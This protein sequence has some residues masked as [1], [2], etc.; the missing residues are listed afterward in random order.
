MQ[1]RLPVTKRKG[2]FASYTERPKSQMSLEGIF[3]AVCL[4]HEL[5]RERLL[6]DLDYSHRIIFLGNSV[7]AA[8]RCFIGWNC[9]AA[10]CGRGYFHAR[11]GRST[12]T[13]RRR[14]ELNRLGLDWQA[15]GRR[16]T[17]THT[18]D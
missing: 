14:D 1:L 15:H 11:S 4:W 10:W 3:A 2:K 13:G 12:T 17:Q 9:S 7:L 18:Q 5:R 16:A 8:W 6:K